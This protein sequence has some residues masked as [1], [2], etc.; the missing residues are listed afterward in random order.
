MVTFPLMRI[1]VVSA[2]TCALGFAVPVGY[3]SIQ[4]DEP[5]AQVYLDSRLVLVAESGAVVE[6][7]PGR[8]FVSLFSPKKVYQAF[9][10]ET[11]E[12]FWSQMQRDGVVSESRRLLSSYERG[13]VREGTEWVYVVEDDTMPVRLSL[14]K[15][16]A[17]YNRD[18]SCVLGTFLGWTAL[19]AVG[20]VLSLFLVKIE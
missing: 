9:R 8:H 14:K 20:M 16:M 3:V 12:Q 7:K 18:A 15:A 11:P 4:T 1:A 10:D 6:A 13:G 2:I 17:T 19:V 5:S